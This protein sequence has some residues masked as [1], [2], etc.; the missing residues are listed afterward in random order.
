MSKKPKNEPPGP[1]GE[2]D[3][4][5]HLNRRDDFALEMFALSKAREAGF[6]ALHSGFYADH[7]TKKSRQFDVRAVRSFEKIS[8]SLSIECKAIGS[9]YPLVVLRTPREPAE[10]FME[11]IIS[12]DRNTRRSGGGHAKT[13]RVPTNDYSAGLPVGRSIMQIGR[14]GEGE[15]RGSDGDLFDRWSQAIASAGDLI[16]DSWQVAMGT[17][18][19]QRFAAIVPILL[20]S[21]DCLWI[22]DY[23]S[24]GNPAEPTTGLQAEQ[25]DEVTFFVDRPLSVTGLARPED[26]TCTI[27]HL[28]IM[29]KKGLSAFL[30]DLER[31]PPNF[32]RRWTLLFPDPNSSAFDGN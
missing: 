30:Q 20:V 11:V 27:S 17:T 7:A 13:M 19:A 1:I 2:A 24:D 29:T 3:I 8:V 32:G 12:T 10:A 16:R 23:D 28:H 9:D 4:I 15:L 14:N 21:D 6:H 25:S 5:D 26:Y 18:R 31:K 22:V